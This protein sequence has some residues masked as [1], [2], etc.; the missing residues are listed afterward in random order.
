MSRITKTCEMDYQA[1]RKWNPADGQKTFYDLKNMGRWAMR[2]E[3]L[4]RLISELKSI[5]YRVEGGPEK[6]PG[7]SRRPVI[8]LRD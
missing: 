4:V 7:R 8:R 3:P 1:V 5:E 2:R 6:V